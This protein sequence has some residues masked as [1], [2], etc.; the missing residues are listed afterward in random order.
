MCRELTNSIK[1]AAYDIGFDL[2]G[3]APVGKYPE[4]QWYKQWLQKGFAGEMG[5]MGRDP[6][7]RGDVANL[8]SG[9]KSVI[10]CGLNY[11]TDHPYSTSLHDKDK[12]WVSRYAWGDDYHE[13]IHSYLKQ[14][15]TCIQGC[16]DSNLNA[17][18]YVDTGPVLERAYAKYGA[19]GWVGKNT[20]IINQQIGSWL[21]LGEIITDIELDYDSPVPDRCGTCTMCIDACPT[22]ALVAAYELDSRLCISYLTIELKGPVPSRLRDK[23]DNNV[24]GCDICQDV[25]P[26]NKSAGVTDEHA[27]IPREGLLAPDLADL[28][29]LT[30]EEFNKKFKDSAVKRT[31]RRGLLRNTLIAIGNSGNPDFVKAVKK[32][33]KDPEP[34]VRVHAAWALWKLMGEGSKDILEA[35]LS[36]EEDNVVRS[37]ITDL[38]VEIEGLRSR[39]VST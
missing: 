15:L 3:I 21:F 26:W 22:D 25:C 2:V 38:L 16:V 24:Y 12:G 7:R 10:T 18:I 9:A 23:I 1:K 6:E 8:L 36:R 30:P 27:F 5:Y 17:R 29:V 14:L 39:C 31:K 11:N 28:A 13:L 19:V 4:T 33:L 35:Q 32:C 37:E 20:C 34:L